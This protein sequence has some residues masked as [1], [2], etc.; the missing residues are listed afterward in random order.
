MKGFFNWIDDRTGIA[1]LTREALFERVPGGARWRY[2]WGST[3]TFAIMVQFIT[4]VFLWMGYSPS[5]TSAWESVYYIQNEMSF[6]WLLRGIHHWTAQIMVILLL[7]H[8]VQVV[9]DSAYRA[10]REF[11]FWFGVILLFLTLAISLTGYLLPWDQKGFWATK[12]ATNL[13]GVVPLIGEDLQK[14][15]VGG[16]D[17]GHHTLTRFF[18]LHAGVLPG[19]LVALIVVHIY[20]FRR[21]GITEAKP[22]T[23]ASALYYWCL[24]GVVFGALTVM[25]FLF[26]DSAK[27]W[28]PWS[29]AGVL[30]AIVLRIA[31]LFI[32]GKDDDSARR[33]RRDGMFW[34]DQILKDAIACVAVMAAVL[35]FVFWKGTELTAPADPSQPYNAARPDWY[36]M[37]L[38]QML[39]FSVFEGALGLVIGAIIVPSILVSAVFMMPLIGTSKVGHWVNVVMLYSLIGGFAV[40][41]AMG[42]NHDANDPEYKLG[43]ANA[44]AEAERLNELISINGGIPPEGALTLL[45]K[46]PKIRGPKLFAANCA[47]CHPHGGE[48]GIGGKVQDP[49]APDLKGVGSHKWIARL[50]DH[51]RYISA[52]YFGNT[53]F[54]DGKMADHLADLDMLPEEIEAVSAALASEAKV[55]GYIEPKGGKEFVDSGFDLMF[56]DLECADCHGIQGEDE[57]RGPSLTGYMS[58]DWMIRF[59]GNPSHADFYGVKNDRMPS[60]LGMTLKDGTEKP[61]ELS[62]Q[63]VELIVD[64]LRGEWP[65]SEGGNN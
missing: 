1:K 26:K 12:V 5:A 43:V 62:R 28:V 8:L 63:D 51:K 52:E 2:V 10:P 48:D 21:H 35:F 9:I 20:L 31:F 6:G 25:A 53:A 15:I 32:R 50:L 45:Y 30:A 40:L 56:E 57:G 61:G 18:A 27:A 47:S 37:S 49:S 39:K 13:A 58:R 36:F 60:F 38:F 55:H 24:L 16:S 29:V 59:V 7:L 3:L 44:H 65:R 23:R 64:W 46:D 17:Y 54:K 11:N 22:A 33:P 19:A 41:T 4:G 14:V 34:P 42:F